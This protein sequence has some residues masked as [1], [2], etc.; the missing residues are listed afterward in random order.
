MLADLERI[1]RRVGR[2]EEM[3]AQVVR[4]GRVTRVDAEL[5][6]VKVLFDELNCLES[7]WLPVLHHMTFQDK[8]FW[9]PDL[10]MHVLVLFLPYA[11]EKGFVVGSPYSLVDRPPVS[12]PEKRHLKFADGTWLEYDRSA[13]KLSICC[14]DQIEIQALGQLTFRCPS[15]DFF[16]ETNCELQPVELRK[17]KECKK[18]AGQ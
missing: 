11:H 17:I 13:G 3:L 2:L 6:R 8:G 10:D 7:D 12:C 9:L 14:V 16:P 18:V 1:A 15:I 4:I 5:A